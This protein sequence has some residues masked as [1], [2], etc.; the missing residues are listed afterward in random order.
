MF[1]Q[2]AARKSIEMKL[3]VKA[4]SS[5]DPA[6]SFDKKLSKHSAIILLHAFRC[7]AFHSD[8]FDFIR[9]A[10]AI[11]PCVPLNVPSEIPSEVHC[12]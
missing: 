8:L 1:M 11:D 12:R 10:S 4:G 7:A 9:D 6:S 3:N 5:I 2:S